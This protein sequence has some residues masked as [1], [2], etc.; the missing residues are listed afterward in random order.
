MSFRSDLYR[1]RTAVDFRPLWKR[2]V[3]VSSAFIVISLLM[4]LIRGLNLSIDFE[5]G[6]VWEVPVDSSVTVE[7]GRDAA[8]IR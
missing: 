2:T 8:G 4:L 6:G 5:G 7:A 1:G 3:V